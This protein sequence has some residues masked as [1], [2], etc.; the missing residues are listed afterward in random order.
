MEFRKYQETDAEII[1]SWINNEREFRLWSADRYKDYPIKPQDINDNYDNCNKLGN[2]YPFTLVDNGK[3]IGHIILR[4]PDNNKDIVRLGFII[5]DHSIRGMG[6]GKRIISEAINYAKSILKAK[7]INL[8]VFSCN[9][10][11]YNCYKKMGFK[12]IGV[13]KNAYIF[14]DEKWDQIE[15]KLMNG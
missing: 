14:Y 15:M 2:F 11:A 7:V 5:V 13:E 10:R 12:E 1:L 6:Y 4:N 9:E 3:V 8:G